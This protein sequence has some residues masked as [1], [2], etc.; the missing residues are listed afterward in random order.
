V[1]LKVYNDEFTKVSYIPINVL[2]KPNIAITE[3]SAPETIDYTDPF[4]I[5]F[6]LSKV[7]KSTPKNLRLVL[8][9][10][11]NK[12]EWTFVEFDSDKGFTLT[13]KGSSM[14]P[15]VNNY[16]ITAF[17]ED[18]K[19]NTYTT[20][21]DF[22]ITSHATFFENIFLYLNLIGKTIEQVFTG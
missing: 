13:S 7:S 9:S 14:K 20:T 6:T 8:Q 15:N 16:R 2:D 11:T 3:F 4:D 18:D 21:K 1:E 22:I 5:T 10:E 17:Y 19:G 12:V